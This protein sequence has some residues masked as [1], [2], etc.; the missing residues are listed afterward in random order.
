[1]NL[2][3]YLRGLGLGIIVTA[4]IL[5]VHYSKQKG[6]TD[7]QVKERAAELGMVENTTLVQNQTAEDLL[8]TID[9]ETPELTVG[10]DEADNAGELSE[11]QDGADEVTESVLGDTEGETDVNPDENSI[12]SIP[13]VVETTPEVVT[14]A[15]DDPGR[16]ES[17]A[18]TEN[19]V[20][21]S[22]S[23][24]SVNEGET[25]TIV[26]SS[27]DS[28]YAVARK[29]EAAGLIDD[30]SDYDTY[31]CNNGYDRY[32]RTGTYLITAGSDNESIAELITGK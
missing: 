7:A 8:D 3:Y 13:E 2:K 20:T 19:T 6:M 15:D 12:E 1:M 11:T 32:I 30:A 21:E 29:L 14:D 4:L 9:N 25:I 24:L 18:E 5:G 22:E 26:V 28:S 27:G 23:D 17:E 31:L 16:G 10:L